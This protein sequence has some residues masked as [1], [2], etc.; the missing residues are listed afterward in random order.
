MSSSVDLNDNCQTF[1]NSCQGY[2]QIIHHCHK[3]ENSLQNQRG[4]RGPACPSL[5]FFN[6]RRWT[7]KKSRTRSFCGTKPLPLGVRRLNLRMP[8]ACL[9]TGLRAK[10]SF[11][12][13]AGTLVPAFPNTA[14]ACDTLVNRPRQASAY[15]AKA[16]FSTPKITPVSGTK[17]L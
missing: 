16:S 2:S 15:T 17:L 12:V 9:V 13:I 11:A 10:P 6:Q 8:L 7:R 4:R 5:Y 3:L 14:Q 1:Y